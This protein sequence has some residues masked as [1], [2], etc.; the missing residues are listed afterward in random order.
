MIS[1]E[2]LVNQLVSLIGG[3]VSE[4]DTA[5]EIAAS[6]LAILR[7]SG[8]LAP[9]VEGD[10][11]EQAR[12]A[13]MGPDAG[14]FVL[15]GR[16]HVQRRLTLGREDVKRVIALAAPIIVS[17]SPPPARVDCRSPGCSRKWE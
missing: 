2:D 12:I 7:A 3:C 13:V 17:T 8:R 15:D 4:N 5:A 16:S 14:C 10:V 11:V 6:V 9:A 1:D